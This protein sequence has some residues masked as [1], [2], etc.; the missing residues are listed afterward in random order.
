MYFNQLAI[1]ASKMTK[2]ELS[3]ITTFSG[4]AIVFGML[5]I[6]VVM[7]AIFG[8]F[9]KA[10]N[11]KSDKKAKPEKL[12]KVKKMAEPSPVKNVVNA[13][14]NVDDDEVIAVISAAVAMMYEGTGKKAVIRS[15][16]PSS[17]GRSAWA[18]AG[19]RDNVRAF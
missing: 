17:V 7:I 11:G 2:G 16:R 14:S 13:T 5:L 1:D 8:L 3:A 6:L 15:I 10:G 9:G 4:V 19:V 12:P 18:N